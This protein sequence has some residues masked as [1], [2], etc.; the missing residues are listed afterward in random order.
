MMT[1][2]GRSY[3]LER[4]LSSGAAQITTPLEFIFHRA[5][6]KPSWSILTASS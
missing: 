5:L 1:I 6:L 2:T 3:L 4:K